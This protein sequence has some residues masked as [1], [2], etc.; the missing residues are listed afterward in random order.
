MKQKS[1]LNLLS[2]VTILALLVGCSPDEEKAAI[3]PPVQ[4][5]LLEK[6][7]ETPFRRFPGEVAAADSSEMSFDVAGRLIEFPATQ[8]VEYKAGAL[9]GRLDETTFVARV[10]SATADFTNASNELERQKQLHTRGVISRSEL[11]R[12]QRAFGVTEAALREA[13]RALDDTRMVA[14]FEGRVART[15]VNNFQNIQAR[16]PVLVFQNNATLEVDIQLP[17]SDMSLGSQGVTAANARE[18]LEAK[19]EFPAIPGRTFDLE[20][21]SFGTEAS[22]SARTFLVTFNLYPPEGQNILPGMTC[23]VL[24][25]LKSQPNPDTE[26]QAGFQVPLR[27]VATADGKSSL[28]KLDSESLK[29]SQIP[30]EMLQLTGETVSVRNPALAPGDEIVVSGVRFLSEGMTV[31]RMQAP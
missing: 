27:A 11:D 25:R 9:L 14:P 21:K 2:G 13:Q 16:Q 8:G 18:R 10:D 6:P 3:A 24:L 12:F 17:E 26:A 4:T 7:G 31:Q 5:I 28:W 30:V 22:R 1:F 20:L 23:T 19:V 29:V 15:M